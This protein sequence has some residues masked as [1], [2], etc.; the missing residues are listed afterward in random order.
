MARD[1]DPGNESLAE[2]L[3]Y[4]FG[5]PALA[6]LALS[7]PSHAHEVDGSRGNERLEF[8][9]DAVLD[10][11][12][13]EVLFRAYPDW[14]EGDLTRS[15]AALV[16][17]QSLADRARAIGLDRFVK[18]GRTEL[19]SAG[20]RKDSVLS[21]TAWRRSSEPC[22][23]TAACP[24]CVDVGR[25]PVLA[26]AWRAAPSRSAATPRRCSR[27]GPTR[28]STDHAQLPDASPGQ[29]NRQRRGALQRGSR[30]R[31]RGLGQ[32]AWGAPSARPS[33][34]PPRRRARARERR[35]M[36]ERIHR[37]GMVA[38][39]GKPNAGK[40]TLLN[41]LL[42]WKLAIVTA[43]PQTTRSRILGILTL[44]GRAAGAARHAG[45]ARFGEAA[46]TSP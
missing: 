24:P 15:R 37:A 28:A 13:A 17:Q 36:S 33:G 31:R 32:R 12:V 27:S 1:S 41:R 10:L 22:T 7:H 46:S 42:G 45:E 4:A 5:D 43:K 23:S 40:S 20:E 14:S 35:W 3:G 21:P 26:T 30:H 19:Q 29:R 2:V 8:L 16:N 9:G 44:R 11:V 25:A 39:L 38:L 18:L 6:E 34:W